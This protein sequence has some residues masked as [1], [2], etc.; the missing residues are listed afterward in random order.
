M[1]GLEAAAL[2]AAALEAAVGRTAAAVAT[3]LAGGPGRARRNRRVRDTGR[4][5]ARRAAEGVL[6]ELDGRGAEALA[7]YTGSPD[8]AEVAHQ[9]ALWRLLRDHDAEDIQPVLREEVRLGLGHAGVPPELLTTGADVVFDALLAAVLDAVRGLRPGDLDRITAASVGTLA[10]AAAG[11]TELLGR[12]ASLAGFHRFAERLRGGVAEAHARIRPPHRGTSRSAPYR[13]LH[14]GPAPS[15][16]T[17]LLLPG[18]RS[19]V[20]GDP[21]AGKSTLVAELAGE[22]ASGDDDRVPFLL[23]PRDFT[24]PFREGAGKLVSYLEALCGAPHDLTPPEDAVEYLLRN[25]RAVVLL[26]GVDELGDPHARHRFARLVESFARLY[27][28]VPVVVTASRTG[29]GTAAL[30]PELFAVGGIEEFPPPRGEPSPRRPQEDADRHEPRYGFPHRTFLEFSAAEHLLRTHRTAESLWG[31]L[32]PLVLAGDVL[33]PQIALRLYEREDEDGTSEL[34][35]LVVAEDDPRLIPFAVDSPRHA[36]L[37]PD[38]IRPLV[39]TAVRAAV[40]I[41]V[42]SYFHHWPTSGHDDVYRRAVKPLEVLARRGAPAHRAAVDEAVRAELASGGSERCA[43][44]WVRHWLGLADEPE[45]WAPEPWAPEPWASVLR[46]TTDP[47]PLVERFG[48]RVLYLRTW[49]SDHS[50]ASKALS[51]EDAGLDPRVL[52]AAPLPWLPA[53]QWRSELRETAAPEVVIGG[54]SAAH[55]LLALPYLESR[56]SFRLGVTGP[57]LVERLSRVR[58]EGSNLSLAG[59]DLPDDARDFLWAWMHREFDVIG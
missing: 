10:A 25:G 48:P 19:V 28:S 9:L 26:D 51:R 4:A 59:L 39:R 12:V 29:Y 3:R 43:V 6:G 38:A 31:A 40:D 8:F 34:L 23:A 2:E 37:T 32:R 20:L 47:S 49:G 58:P 36:H 7:A 41:G 42:E 35:R 55:C 17:G 56:E 24:A 52:L 16:S 13:R 33:V 44:E 1:S 30:D 45:P 5:A 11:N 21:G 53:G 50:G 18:R 22:V 14:V 57:R 46:G 15:G 54:D 27:P